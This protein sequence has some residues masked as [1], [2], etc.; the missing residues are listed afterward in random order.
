MGK[1]FL[2]YGLLGWLMEILWTGLGSFVQGNIMLTSFTY[3]WMFPIYG[4]A[5][6]FEP[7][8]DQIKQLPWFWRGAIWVILILALEYFT[9]WTLGKLLGRC[10]WDYRSVTPYHIQGLIRLDYIPAWFVVGLAFERIHRRL[11]KL[12]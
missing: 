6:F 8:H 1:R 10:P 2:I 9:G 12:A 7:I 4:L 5:V 11:D 3:L